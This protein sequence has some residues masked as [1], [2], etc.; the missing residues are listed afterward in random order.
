MF[1]GT[2]SDLRR[3]FGGDQALTP[4]WKRLLIRAGLSALLPCPHIW[5]PASTTRGPVRWCS[6]CQDFEHLTEAEFYAHFGTHY[7][8]LVAM[9]ATPVLRTKDL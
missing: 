2:G 9:L 7:P 4:L 5:R 3:A 8:A 6:I 1:R